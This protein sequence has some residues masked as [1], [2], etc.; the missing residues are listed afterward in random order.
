MDL[1]A[2][3]IEGSGSNSLNLSE[4]DAL[5]LTP[6]GHSAIGDP[7]ALVVLGGVDD[8]IS[9]P[10]SWTPGASVSFGGDTFDTF[11]SGSATLFIE[12]GIDT[13]GLL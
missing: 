8:F 11:T 5:A 9:S 13:T 10:D 2:I 3:D 12:Q 7:D 1:E 6:T 4:S